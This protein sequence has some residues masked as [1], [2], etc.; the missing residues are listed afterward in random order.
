MWILLTT[1]SDTEKGRKK[2]ETLVFSTW[3]EAR[4]EMQSKWNGQIRKLDAEFC[5]IEEN[6][7]CESDHAYVC[8]EDG[9]VLNYV[10]TETD[11]L[12][13]ELRERGKK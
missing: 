2:E 12:P 9:T 1:Y 4:A 3:E 6:S 5:I 13:K 7:G 10:I 11:E 8:L